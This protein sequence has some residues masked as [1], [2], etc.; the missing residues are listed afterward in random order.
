[1]VGGDLATTY[2]LRMAA[3][4]LYERDDFEK[5][6]YSNEDKFPHGR[7]E[8]DVV[9]K[10]ARKRKGI[11]TTSCGRILDAAS[12]LLGICTRRTYE[13]EPAMKLESHAA[14]GKSYGIKP[15]IEWSNVAILDTSYLMNWLWENRN[16]N[17]KNLAFSVEEYI[18]EGL[19]EIAVDYAKREHVKS[20]AVSGGCAYNEHIVKAI[21]RKVEASSLIFLLNEKVPAGDG[22]ISFGQAIV[23]DA[24]MR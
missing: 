16:R 4:V 11:T 18:A 24:K 22:G 13:G 10:E 21:R 5:F 9:L 1:M 3:G 19:A 7:E 23:A 6:L 15:E 20:V 12:A 8:I 14:G 2:P 17:S